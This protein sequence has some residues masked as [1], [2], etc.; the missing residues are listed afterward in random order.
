[1][2]MNEQ[3]INIY[4][5]K[6]IKKLEEANRI[7]LLNETQIDIL[8]QSL[9]SLRAE[10]DAEADKHPKAAAEPQTTASVGPKRVR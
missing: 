3:F 5:E 4:V 10:L 1:M 8:T 7:N 6:L 2:Q 9:A